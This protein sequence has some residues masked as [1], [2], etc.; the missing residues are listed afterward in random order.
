[1]EVELH[2]VLISPLVGRVQPA[3]RTHSFCYH[4][5]PPTIKTLVPT[6]RVAR[7]S[8]NAVEKRCKEQTSHY[9]DWAILTVKICWH[10]AKGSVSATMSVRHTVCT[11]R[12]W[13]PPSTHIFQNPQRHSY[14]LSTHRHAHRLLWTG[15]EAKHAAPLRAQNILTWQPEREA[16]TVGRKQRNNLWFRATLLVSEP[17]EQKRKFRTLN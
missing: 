17:Y 10:A 7:A 14:T 11:V 16:G 2:A 4:P 15:G 13:C 3:S 9:I 5:P 12:T 1:M 8:M 6:G